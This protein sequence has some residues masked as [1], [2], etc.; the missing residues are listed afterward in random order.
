MQSIIRKGTYNFCISASPTRCN[1]IHQWLFLI[2]I[3]LIIPECYTFQ[4]LR[5]KDT[6]EE[7]YC[8]KDSK[9]ILLQ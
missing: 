4:E 2:K 9:H 5:L 6:L 7:I 1:L 8:D 3:T